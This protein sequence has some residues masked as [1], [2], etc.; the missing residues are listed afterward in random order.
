MKRLSETSKIILTWALTLATSTI[1]ILASSFVTHWYDA[2]Q[3]AANRQADAILNS[4]SYTEVSDGRALPFI[5]WGKNLR[6]L[7][8]G[9]ADSIKQMADIVR[10]E[11]TTCYNQFDDNCADRSALSINMMRKSLGLKTPSSEDILALEFGNGLR[12]RLQKS[13]KSFQQ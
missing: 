1:A 12:E 7:V 11:N 3:E 5:E 8:F 13:I 9:D 4:M 10:G 2:R 6:V